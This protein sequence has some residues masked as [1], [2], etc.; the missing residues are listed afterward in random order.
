MLLLVCLC[1]WL[2]QNLLCQQIGVVLK[3]SIRVKA[4]ET[5]LVYYFN[6]QSED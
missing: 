3:S 5:H 1:P 6:Y 4:I 2:C